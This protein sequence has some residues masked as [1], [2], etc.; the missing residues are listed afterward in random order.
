M[1]I[2]TSPA[3]R[4]LNVVD[5]PQGGVTHTR[6][7]AAI[8][9]ALA[10]GPA[11]LPVPEQPAAVREDVVAAMRPSMPAETVENDRV[12]LV[13][14]TSGA[15]GEPK[16]VLLGAAAIAASANATHSR[17]GGAGRWLLALPCTHVG[18]LMVLAR[19]VIAGTDPVSVDLGGGFRPEAFTAASHRFLSGSA[20][21]RYTALVPRQLD[22]VLDGGA[23]ALEALATFDSVLVGGSSSPPELL[24]RARGAGVRVVTTYG[25]TETCGGCV[26]DGVPLRGVS[27][28]TSGDGRIK[29]AGPVLA[30][31]YRLQPRLTAQVFAHG[32]FTSSD[33]GRIDSDGG[34][35]VSGRI[36]DV[37]VSGGVNVPLAAVDSLLAEHPD[38]AAV[39]T[40][41]L[42]DPAWGHRL[43]AVLVPRDPAFPPTLEALRAFVALRAPAA[44]APKSLVL[45]RSLPMLPGGK[46]D[47]RAVVAH[48]LESTTA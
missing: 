47:R 25:M 16:G 18:G 44:H 39:A 23:A 13:V 4:P 27:V 33:L 17:L 10:S 7:L 8:E 5:V 15:T 22:V 37:A 45:V 21:R 24:D 20:G 11:I 2:S 48:V 40:I 31:G 3:G 14:P 34:L 32:W 26:Y 46:V 19:S 29:I 12:A 43:V 28:E 36:D 1:D 38:V 6:M 30:S 9:A 42:P 41:G 35:F